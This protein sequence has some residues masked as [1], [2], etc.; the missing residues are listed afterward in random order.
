MILSVNGKNDPIKR[1][2][3]R[4]ELQSQ[5][6]DICYLIYYLIEV[7][8]NYKNKEKLK[9]KYRKDTL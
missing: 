3:Q 9:I 8:L 6:T 1:Q 7:H 2:I 4:S 5:N